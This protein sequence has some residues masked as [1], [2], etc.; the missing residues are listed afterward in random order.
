MSMKR[1]EYT[2]IICRGFCTF[3][4]EGKEESAC[5]TYHF[6]ESN[7]TSGELKAGIKGIKPEPDFSR[8][9]E[10]ER[11]VCEQCDFF[12]DGCDFREGL[13]AQPC[14]GYAIVEWFLRKKHLNS[15][16]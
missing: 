5:G 13:G 11:L 12:V 6:L 8:D 7:L 4:K 2:D 15:S 10:I 3:Y 16:R 9:K 14:G 1:D